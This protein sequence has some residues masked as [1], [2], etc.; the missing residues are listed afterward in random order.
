MTPDLIIP[1]HAQECIRY[2][3]SPS[4]TGGTRLRLWHRVRILKEAVPMKIL[5]VNPFGD[6]EYYGQDNLA[7]IAPPLT[8]ETSLREIYTEYI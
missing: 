8:T 2:A 4:S 5:V 6:T 1:S 3:P 7:R